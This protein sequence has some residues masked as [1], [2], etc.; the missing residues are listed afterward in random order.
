MGAGVKKV[1][2]LYLPELPHNRV[3]TYVSNALDGSGSLTDFVAFIER[4]AYEAFHDGE[5]LRS[6]DQPNRILE[7]LR[8]LQDL[9]P[10]SAKAPL[11]TYLEAWVTLDDELA[12]VHPAARHL[13]GLYLL[14]DQADLWQVTYQPDQLYTSLTTYKHSFLQS[15]VNAFRSRGM[16]SHQGI[17]A[18]SHPIL[19]RNKIQLTHD[20]FAAGQVSLSLDDQHHAFL[21]G[22]FGPAFFSRLEH[23][24]IQRFEERSLVHNVTALGTFLEHGPGA[25]DSRD[26]QAFVD[27][28]L[29][30][31]RDFVEDY[32]TSE[33]AAMI[34]NSV[35]RGWLDPWATD[36]GDILESDGWAMD[37]DYQHVRDGAN[38]ALLKLAIDLDVLRNEDVRDLPKQVADGLK[39]RFGLHLLMP[40]RSLVLTYLNRAA[41]VPEEEPAFAAAV[42]FHLWQLFRIYA[43]EALEVPVDAPRVRDDI[44]ATLAQ[45]AVFPTMSTLEAFT[46][47]GV[48]W[49][50]GTD[51]DWVL[52]KAGK[53]ALTLSPQQAGVAARLLQ[54]IVNPFDS[55]IRASGRGAAQSL[56]SFLKAETVKFSIPTGIENVERAI[57][58]VAPE[59]ERHDR[60][61]L[62][63]LEPLVKDQLGDEAAAAIRQIIEHGR[64]P[65]TEGPP[66]SNL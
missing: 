42:D 34:K 45:P 7:G 17:M 32:G 57:E 43:S 33:P 22:V 39:A 21:N 3:T 50:G 13:I 47:Q 2:G 53:V 28:L 62:R 64:L 8:A 51:G 23:V 1:H 55:V 65:N 6:T 56:A 11:D 25:Y 60:A 63:F 18:S 52:A 10:A 54:R 27:R 46:G 59:D 44:L 30:H 4:S 40:R 37:I 5:A 48:K 9:P 16:P 58:L 26:L 41:P 24:L 61:D 66:P 31:E 20:P 49:A 15:V 14:V 38:L 35:A 19:R 29:T 12:D 36:E